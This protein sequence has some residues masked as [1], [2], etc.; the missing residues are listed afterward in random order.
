MSSKRALIG[1]IIIIIGVLLLFKNMGLLDFYIPRILFSWQAILIY[2]G[3]VMVATKRKTGLIPMV[4]G[5]Y[6]ILPEIFPTIPW[7]YARNWWPLLLILIGLGLLIDRSGKSRYGNDF[8]QSTQDAL[9]ETSILGGGKKILNSKSF[10]GGR[11]T[12]ILGGCEV[13][14]SD[15]ELAEGTTVLDIVSIMGGSSLIIP[16][17]W[18]ISLE[19]SSILGGV[20]DERRNTTERDLSRTLVIKGLSLMGGTEIK[21]I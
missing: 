17:Y 11:I 12:S 15:C 13:D 14:L 3:V 4:I 6:F 8:S 1:I 20:S 2:V 5:I 16:D 19:M 18:N 10:S 9:D 7:D 21:S